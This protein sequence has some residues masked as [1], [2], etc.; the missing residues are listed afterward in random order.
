MS[1]GPL[2]TIYSWSLNL[3]SMIGISLMRDV[4]S[5]FQKHFIFLNFVKGLK[6]DDGTR[7]YD[8]KNNS[9]NFKLRF[10]KLYE[11][12]TAIT[13]YSR[14]Q[15]QIIGPYS[16]I[17]DTSKSGYNGNSGIKTLY[18]NYVAPERGAEGAR[19]IPSLMFNA[20]YGDKGVTV[21]APMPA[22][23]AFSEM[24]KK[25]F[26]RSVEIDMDEFVPPTYENRGNDFSSLSSSQQSSSS[27]SGSEGG[28]PTFSN[29]EVPF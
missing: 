29:D 1:N 3:N 16:I 22:A 24:C 25:I 17:N 23:L 20:K 7:T 27:I 18:I 11:L 26:D 4:E 5:K 10:E 21:G 19:A 15:G 8:F 2:Q 9:I 28:Y 6:K 14:G 12:Y 13:L